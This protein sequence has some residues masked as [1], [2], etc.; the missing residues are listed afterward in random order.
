MTT[1]HKHRIVT[2]R[3]GR[4]GR[5]VRRALSTPLVHRT[6]LEQVD[7]SPY[8]YGPCANEYHN[9]RGR[10]CYYL[11]LL[12]VLHRWTGLTLYYSED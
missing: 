9:N 2:V 8:P 6:D 7:A 12:S 5:L 1:G 3:S 10:D 4:V 11:S